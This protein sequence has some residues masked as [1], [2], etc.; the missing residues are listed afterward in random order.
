VSQTFLTI[1]KPKPNES[2]DLLSFLNL[3]KIDFDAI[4]IGVPEFEKLKK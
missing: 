4:L 2:D 3:S 1:A